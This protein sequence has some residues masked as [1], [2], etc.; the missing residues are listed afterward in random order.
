MKNAFK[1]VFILTISLSLY[2]VSKAQNSLS[3]CYVNTSNNISFNSSDKELNEVFTWAKKQALAYAFEEDAVGQ[4]YEAALPGREVFC[5]RDVSHQAMGAHFLGLANHTKNMLLK[6]AGNVSDKRDW[7]SL[8][9]ITRH[10]TPALQDYLNDEEFWYNLPANFDILDCCFRMYNLTGDQAYLNDSVFLNFYRRTVYDYVERWD[11]SIDKVMNRDR[12]LNNAPENNR[13]FKTNRG[14]PGYHEGDDGYIASLDLLTTQ[15]AAF[16]AYSQIQVLRCNDKEA[17]TFFSK[18]DEIK[19]FITKEWWDK[20]NQQ[21]YTHVGKD[22]LLKSRGFDYSTLYFGSFSDS[23]KLRKTLSGLLVFL[24]KQSTQFIEGL[25]HLPEVL[26]HCEEPELARDML[27]SVLKSERK[28]YP[29]ASFCTVGAM[30]AGL[31]GVEMEEYPSRTSIE[32]GQFGEQMFITK[33]RLT[34]QTEWAEINHV[35]IKRNDISVRHEGKTKSTLINNSGPQLQ[36]KAC[37]QGVFK[38][39]K[40]NGNPVESRI[41]TL[42]INGEKITWVW[43]VVGAGETMTIEAIK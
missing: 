7:C 38:S 30:V 31:M 22:H 35:P 15:Q 21:F 34:A 16:E 29:E 20:N 42:L 19:E 14:I 36:W 24:P 40:L 8:W 9:E 10:G 33:S 17:L 41:E 27:L 3:E 32:T 12:W 5:M 39:M 18:A 23:I 1:F 37:F 28:E 4:W 6:F 11:V 2:L 13:K 26:Y 43:A 25:S